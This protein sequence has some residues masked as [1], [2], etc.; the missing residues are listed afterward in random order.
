MRPFLMVCKMLIMRG[1]LQIV[2]SDLAKKFFLPKHLHKWKICSNFA[3]QFRLHKKAMKNQQLDHI[4]ASLKAQVQQDEAVAK[5]L[6]ASAARSREMLDIIEKLRKEN[7][8][9]K[10]MKK[11]IN[12]TFNI[13]RDYI[14]EQRI[15]T[16]PLYQDEQNN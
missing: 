16:I 3:V 8:K 12:N 13:G 15:Q 4:I 11:V 6:L 2:K 7:E 9:L 14:Q 1:N 10:E 5:S